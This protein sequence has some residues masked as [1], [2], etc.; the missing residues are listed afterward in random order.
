METI[1]GLILPPELSGYSITRASNSSNVAYYG[2]NVVEQMFF[3][4][5]KNGGMYLYDLTKPTGSV[6]A[7]GAQALHEEA[8]AAVSVGKYFNANVIGKYEATKMTA[9]KIIPRPPKFQPIDNNTVPGIK[10]EFVV[11]N[12]GFPAL[13]VNCEERVKADVQRLFEQLNPVYRLKADGYFLG[14]MVA[15]RWTMVFNSLTSV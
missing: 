15:G 14:D 13:T 10:Y 9:D 12:D 2:A 4:Q 5:F 1:D 8:Q 3:I 7:L 11:D 6:G